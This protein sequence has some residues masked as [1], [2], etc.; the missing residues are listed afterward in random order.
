MELKDLK[1]G[2]HIEYRN[3]EKGILLKDTE[4][5]DVVVFPKGGYNKFVLSIP[6]D[7]DWD[8]VC[9]SQPLHEC[10]YLSF[11][12]KGRIVWQR[13]DH[14]IQIDGKEI[15]ISE[16]SYNNLKKHFKGEQ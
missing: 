11:D 6:E 10:E 3:G 13:N 1:T 12:K 9:I 2:M 14:T 16:E 4:Y 15:V 8:I 5:G 7:Y